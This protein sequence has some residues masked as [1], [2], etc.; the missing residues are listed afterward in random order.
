MNKVS[1]TSLL[2]NRL[3]YVLYLIALLLLPGAL[4]G[5][6]MLWLANRY[7]SRNASAQRKR[8]RNK[9]GLSCFHCG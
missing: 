6:P 5:A 1:S 7:M 9:T 2:R 4:I 8:E 3:K